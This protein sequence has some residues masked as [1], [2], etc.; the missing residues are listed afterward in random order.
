MR[1]AQELKQKVKE[2]DILNHLA[3]QFE[4]VLAREGINKT[5]NMSAEGLAR[6]LAEIAL[7]ESEFPTN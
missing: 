4:M 2:K 1:D 6:E 5:W 7:E 3:E